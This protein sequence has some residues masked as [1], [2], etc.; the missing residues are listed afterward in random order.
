MNLRHTV[1]LSE[2]LVIGV[3]K[4]ISTLLRLL[5]P[6]APVITGGLLSATP[7]TLL[8]L[9]TFYLLFNRDNREGT[10]GTKA[11]AEAPAPAPYPKAPD[12]SAS[13]TLASE[14]RPR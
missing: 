2:G 9:P 12:R 8:V 14:A 10:D 13:I 6:N 11:E 4:L 7:L 5:D 1:A 3:L